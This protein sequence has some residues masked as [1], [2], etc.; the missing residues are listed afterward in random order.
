MKD[1]EESLREAFSAVA[2]DQT[3]NY[4]NQPIPCELDSKISEVVVLFIDSPPNERSPFFKYTGENISYRLIAF[5]ERRAAMGVREKS[6]QR[7][8]EGLAALVIEDY[9]VD[10]RDNLIRLAA[11]YD[12]ATKIGI[13][14]EELFTEAASYADNS[15][16]QSIIEF[17]ER[18]PEERSLE[19]FTYKEIYGSDGFR[20]EWS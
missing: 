6:R 8:L 9:R 14:P 10:W 7:L 18:K 2:K 20:Y 19:A 11:L 13:S 1:R 16:A 4:L 12:A 5:A 17:L 15:V 3:R